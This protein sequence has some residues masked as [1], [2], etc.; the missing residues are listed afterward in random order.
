[1]TSDF[2]QKIGISNAF[3]QPGARL[4][5]R[6]D[7]LPEGY[8]SACFSQTC[9]WQVEKP[10]VGPCATFVPP[11]QSFSDWCPAL[12]ISSF[13]VVMQH[14]GSQ[15]SVDQAGGFVMNIKIMMEFTN[16]RSKLCEF[17]LHLSGYVRDRRQ[18]SPTQTK[19]SQ[20]WFS[21][22]VK[23][24][25]FDLVAATPDAIAIP[26]AVPHSALSQVS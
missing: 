25:F 9:L 23:C 7:W 12:R 13:C 21:Q 17:P 11:S 14:N 2:R 5:L 24:N 18:S 15:W 10:M 26:H 20:F 16:S 19:D 22:F 3:E 6:A 8:A 1:M 4:C